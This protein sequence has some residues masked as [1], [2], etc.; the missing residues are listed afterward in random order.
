MK[1]RCSEDV[2]LVAEGRVGVRSMGLVKYR[3]DGSV[4]ER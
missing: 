2:L 4:R 3:G 1:R